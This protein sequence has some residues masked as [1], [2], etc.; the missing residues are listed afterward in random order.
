MLAKQVK[1]LLGVLW[2]LVV[3]G[4]ILPGTG[5][6]LS[7]RPVY[8]A[9]WPELAVPADG[10]SAADLSGTYRAISEAAGPLV[11]P[12]GGHPQE[13]FLFVPIGGV[14]PAAELGRR[15]LIW[16]LC[17]EFRGDSWDELAEMAAA[18]EAENLRLGSTNSAGWVRVR[19]EPAGSI[20]VSA[21]LG[22]RAL[23]RR[24][25]VPKRQPLW[26][27]QPNRYQRRA[28]GVEVRGVFPSPAVEN[29]MGIPNPTMGAIC[30]F[31]RARDG[32]L[33]MLENPYAGVAGG[34]LEFQKWWRW[35][36]V[37]VTGPPA[38]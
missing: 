28:G 10:R 20:K 12:A 11:Y 26:T 24:E 19:E 14:K 36:P 5:T 30:T 35:L 29:P 2:L 8:P 25:L 9:D 27:Y 1:P 32:S 33:I 31:Y 3:P 34:N 15:H 6:K 38:P 22:E 37:P 17:G 18:I 21:G 23:I 4:C 13:R 16:H 7:P